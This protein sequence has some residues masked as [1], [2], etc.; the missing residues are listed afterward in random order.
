MGRKFIELGTQILIGIIV[1]I[2][3]GVILAYIIQDARF[4]SGP[5]PSPANPVAQNVTATLTPTDF[6]QLQMDHSLPA[7]PLGTRVATD[8]TATENAILAVNATRTATLSVATETTASATIIALSTTT[9]FAYTSVSPTPTSTVQSPSGNNSP[10]SLKLII[11]LVII[12]LLIGI[13]RLVR[14]FSELGRAV[15]DFRRGIREGLQSDDDEI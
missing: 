4:A 11:V 14:I 12:V 3:G 7:Q 2:I 10:I 13:G 15:R 9:N 1:T 5:I 8:Q 6:Q